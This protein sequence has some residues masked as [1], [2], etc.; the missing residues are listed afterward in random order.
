MAKPL[1]EMLIEGTVLCDGG[2]REEARCRGYGTP[3]VL[4]EFPDVVR[5]IHQDYYRA[6][7]SVLRAM[8][9]LAT[10]SHLE[11]QGEDGWGSRT[12]E[13]NRTAI[14]LAKEAAGDD[15]LVAGVLGPSGASDPGDGTSR[16]RVAAEW[17]DQ[18]AVMVDAGVDLLV[19][20]SFGRLDEA[21][22]A[23]ACC[24][25]TDLPTV[26]TVDI[27]LPESQK[28]EA[29]LGKDQMTGDGAPPGEAARTLAGEGA[30]VVGAGGRR[31]PEDQWPVV[32]EMRD[33]V[34]VP[35]AFLPGGYRTN[36]KG[37]ESV[38]E[39]MQVYGMEMAMYS[40]K[41]KTHGIDLVGGSN[42][43]GPTLTRSVAQSLGCE[44]VHIE[45]RPR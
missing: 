26:V 15:A 18:I 44:R 14:R 30:D 7:A 41:A 1:L 24:K 19:C 38:R 4:V 37:W 13:I 12:E 35:I 39:A 43:V 10:R 16:D 27:V 25:K 34:D 8:T 17:D 23:L 45:L 22:L 32:L 20:D 40:L 29:E 11:R 31:E 42:G 6:G 5:L 9:G 3:Q 21:R 36:R 33:A 28:N 2:N